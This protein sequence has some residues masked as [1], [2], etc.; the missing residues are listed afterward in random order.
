MEAEARTIARLIQGEDA[1][2]GM[3]AFAAK[4]RPNYKGQS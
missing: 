2:E 1:Q 3:R 4:E